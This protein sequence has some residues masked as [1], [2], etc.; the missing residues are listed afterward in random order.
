MA[1]TGQTSSVTFGT[2]AITATLI[3]I[4]PP[5]EA[6]TADIALPT[7][8]LARGDYLPYSPGDLVEGGE[9]T[10][11]FVND[12]DTTISVGTATETITWTKPLNS[13]DTTAAN[14]AFPGYIKSVK[15]DSYE[16]DTRGTITVVVKVAGD[17]TKTAAA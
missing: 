6:I 14:W 1:V 15:E 9:Y 13:G 4:D 3:S 5:E 10:L 11:Q 2:S 16:T 7:L 12:F 8:A 17:V